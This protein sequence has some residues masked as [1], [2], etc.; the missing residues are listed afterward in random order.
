MATKRFDHALLIL[1]AVRDGAAVLDER[2]EHITLAGGTHRVALYTDDGSCLT[3][4]AAAALRRALKAGAR[5][6]VSEA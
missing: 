6:G 3:T 4:A 1:R 2:A 5:S